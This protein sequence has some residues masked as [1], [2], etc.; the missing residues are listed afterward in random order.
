MKK[1]G[2]MASLHYQLNKLLIQKRF[3]SLRGGFSDALL[4]YRL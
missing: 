4:V 2:T 3:S 1:G